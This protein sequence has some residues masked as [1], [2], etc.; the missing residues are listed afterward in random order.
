MVVLSPGVDSIEK[1]PPV[2]SALSLMLVRPR[3]LAVLVWRI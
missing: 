3:L 2:N 1:L